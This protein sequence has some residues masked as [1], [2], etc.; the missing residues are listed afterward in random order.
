MSRV[1]LR[2]RIDI[3]GQRARLALA[4]AL[5]SSSTLLLLDDVFSAIDT[6][7]ASGLW[8]KVFCSD[9]LKGRTVVLVTQQPW[10]I[11][12]ADLAITLEGG[13]VNAI[14]QNIGAVRQ[15]RT[16]AYNEQEEDNG[17]LTGPSGESTPVLK[18]TQLNSAA[19]ISQKSEVDEEVKLTGLSGRLICK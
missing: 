5:Y 6:K 15:P 18:S 2:Q 3:G 13:K 10:V 4:R 8:N 7:T 9:I 12:Q 11:E 1:E 19:L 17:R 14:E 16:I